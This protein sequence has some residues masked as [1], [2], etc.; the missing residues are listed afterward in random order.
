MAIHPVIIPDL[1]ILFRFVLD[2]KS[3]LGT[4]ELR[5]N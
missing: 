4:M 2:Q 3:M 5:Q 1:F